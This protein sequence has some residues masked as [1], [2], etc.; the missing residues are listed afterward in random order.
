MFRKH[1]KGLRYL[2][3]IEIW[4]RL[5]FSIM[6]AVYVL[7]MDQTLGFDDATK[8][9]LYGAFL[10]ASYIFPLL[11]GWLGVPRKVRGQLSQEILKPMDSWRY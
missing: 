1:P 2:F 10:G 3:V 11:G 6:S 5:G 9:T 7:Y 4:E 8:G